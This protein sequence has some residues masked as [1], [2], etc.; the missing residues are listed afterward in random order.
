MDE[1]NLQRENPSVMPDGVFCGEC[2]CGESGDTERSGESEMRS[3]SGE[4]DERCMV[5][6][7]SGES[8]ENG[9]RC[10]T[11]ESE[12]SGE[13]EKRSDSGECGESV[14]W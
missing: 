12:R 11:S 1:I 9:E 4:C 8:G 10:E 3:D 2:V 14:V 5:S 6:E 13:C 7:R